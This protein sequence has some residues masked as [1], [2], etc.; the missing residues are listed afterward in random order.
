V[1]ESGSLTPVS[2]AVEDLWVDFQREPVLRGV[3]CTFG[4][5]EFWGLIGPSGSGKSVL[6]K[7]I[8]GIISPSSGSVSISTKHNG[9][10]P[11][12]LMFQEGALFDSLSV[13]DNVAFPLVG[14][15]VPIRRTKR[16]DGV[17]SNGVAGEVIDKVSRI[18]SRVGLDWAGAKMPAELSGGMRRRVSLARSLVVD[19][20]ILLLDDPTGGLD[21]VASSVIMELIA[22]IQRE[23][24]TSMIVVSQD[25]RRLIPMVSKVVALF[26]GQIAAQCGVEDLRGCEE[27][28]R[29]FIS[30]RYDLT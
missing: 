28:V 24:K 9:K 22:E 14:G 6:L 1:A 10:V 20:Q 11:L 5:G 12:A 18:L 16:G 27:G 13:F 26:D 19:P 8:A 2:I 3:S 4:V 29:K 7:A 25:L 23:S 17:G 30:C 21:P 15:S